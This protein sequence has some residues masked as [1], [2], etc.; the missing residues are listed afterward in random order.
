[1]HKLLCSIGAVSAALAAPLSHAAAPSDWPSYNRTLSSERFSPLDQITSANAAQLKLVCSY[2]T[3]EATAFQSGLVQVDGALYATTEHDTY[4][5]DPDTCKL[6]WRSHE[7]F[8]DGYLGSQR[9]VAIE[10]GRVFR[11][12]GD[13]NVY[14]YDQKTGTRLWK[15]NIGEPAK[16]ETVPAAPIVS[17]GMVYIGNAGGDN[18]GVKGRMYALDAATGT[19]VWEYYL[20]PKTAQDRERGPQGAG[21]PS[22]ASWNNAQGVEITGGA[23]WT[24]YSFDAAAGE[25]YVPGGNP[26]PDFAKHLRRGANLYAGSVVVLDAKTGAYKR[27]F[28]IVPEDFHDYDVSSAPALFTSKSGVDIMA[29]T[30]KDGF[31]YAYDRKSGKRLYRVAVTTQFNTAAKLSP[32]GTRFCPGT[33]GGSEWNGPAYDARHDAVITGQVDWCS[34]VKVDDDDTIKSVAATQSWSGAGG[35]FGKN[36]AQSKWAGWLS[37]L[38][39]VSGKQRWRFKAPN[40]VIGG[41]T[42]TA[43]AVVFFG[44]MG[45]N[46]YVLDSASGKTLWQRDMHGA[47]GGGVITYD[48]GAGQKV[49]VSTGMQSKIWP[50]PK[51]TAQI[52]IMAVQ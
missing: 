43:G 39:A 45:G 34:T 26:A 13:G 5:I 2:D 14:A 27:H 11:G 3:G 49:A 20:V 30:P 12:A 35:G 52:Q 37:S 4:S 22:K 41:V 1:M 32:K 8:K 23:T 17:N 7:D 31:I 16:G 9:G 6:N 29:L 25:L 10:A 33:Q 46:F 42:P 19:I 40:P 47:V 21:T 44:D 48:T 18:R 51:A 38:D 15:T 28:S 36:D 50:T 24:S